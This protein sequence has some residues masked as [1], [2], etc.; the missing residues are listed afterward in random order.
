MVAQTAHLVA[1]IYLERV[2]LNDIVVGHIEPKVVPYHNT[3]FV[4]IVV[5][6]IVGDATR[7]QTYHVVVHLLVQADRQ[8]I[9]LAVHAQQILAHTPIATLDED[10]LTIAVDI[11]HGKINDILL[12]AVLIFLDAETERATVR[13]R[14]S[15]KTL[16][17][18]GIELGL[19]VAVRPPQTRMVHNQ[20]RHIGTAH[21]NITLLT[22]THTD[23]LLKR[24]ALGQNLAANGKRL[25]LT[26]NVA[27]V[28]R[29]VQLSPV[30]RRKIRTYPGILHHGRTALHH[31]AVARDAGQTTRHIGHPIPAG[32]RQIARAARHAVRAFALARLL[33]VGIVDEHGNGILSRAID[34]LS[35]VEARAQHVAAHVLGRFFRARDLMAVEPE[36]GIAVRVVE[37]QPVVNALLLPFGYLKLGT[38]PIRLTVLRLVHT[39]N[40]VGNVRILLTPCRHIRGKY[41]TG[42]NALHAVSKRETGS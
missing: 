11:E 14:P 28:G 35:H 7:P 21:L 38:I 22:G 9:L 25:I 18:A 8:L 40:I 31:I 37:A 42:D 10:A 3:I 27:H 16:H 6:L 15:I 1:G 32:T 26:G 23:L 13:N 29:E 17:L 34:K 4:A 24:N 41:H 39:V 12:Y 19:A 2:V 30:E 20:R 36:I 33:L 5:E